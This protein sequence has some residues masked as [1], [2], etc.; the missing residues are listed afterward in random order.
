MG[1]PARLQKCN[2]AVSMALGKVAQNSLI[3]EQ[4][5]MLWKLILKTA[6]KLRAVPYT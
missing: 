3:V 5:R 4:E 1:N 6:R 2:L